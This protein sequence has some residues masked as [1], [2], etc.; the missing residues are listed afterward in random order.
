MDVEHSHMVDVTPSTQTLIF[1]SYD[2]LALSW[3]PDGFLPPVLFS[4]AMPTNYRVDIVLYELDT[5]TNEWSQTRRLLSNTINDGSEVVTVT[6]PGVSRSD[7]SP[8]AVQVQ[9]ICI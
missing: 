6:E 8:V 4:S 7:V 2:T 1:T 9:Y 3:F 5:S